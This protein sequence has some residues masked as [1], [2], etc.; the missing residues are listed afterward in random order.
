MWCHAGFNYAPISVPFTRSYFHSRNIFSSYHRFLWVTCLTGTIADRPCLNFNGR[1]SGNKG[2]RSTFTIDDSLFI[3]HHLLDLSLPQI[4]WPPSGNVGIIRPESDQTRKET[5][6]HRVFKVVFQGWLGFRGKL[7]RE[8]SG[9]W[10][11]VIF[12]LGDVGAAEQGGDEFKCCVSPS[13][14]VSLS[15]PLEQTSEVLSSMGQIII[16]NSQRQYAQDW[17]FKAC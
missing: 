1:S 5:D 7:R 17:I 16:A 11:P 8:V 13:L 4:W 15:G 10:W 3:N 6:N 9:G 12:P 2:N 14:Q